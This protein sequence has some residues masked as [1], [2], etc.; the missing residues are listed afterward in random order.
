MQ[1]FWDEFC[2][3]DLKISCIASHLHYNTISCILRCVF[4]LLQTCVQVGLDWAKPMM[5]LLLH[6]TCSYIFM[7]MYFTFSIFLYIELYWDFFDCLFPPP[8]LSLSLVYI[9]CIMAPKRS[10][11]YPRILFILGHPLLLTLLP[12]L[13]GSVMKRPK[14]TSLRTFL[15]E[16]FIQNAKSFCQTSQILTYPLSFTVG[17][18]SHCVA[19]RSFV[20]LC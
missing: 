10:L 6:I 11:F 8:P 19:S 1:K 16:A 17:V 3:F 5:F 9:S 15:D 14:Q 4:T 12:P 2:I 20:H 7:H 18:G 13:F